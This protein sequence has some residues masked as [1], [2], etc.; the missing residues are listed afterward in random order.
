MP[1]LRD[2]DKYRVTTIIGEVGD[3]R[4][5]NVIIVDNHIYTG[6]NMKT[7]LD[8]VKSKSPRS[9]TTAVLF[10][11]QDVPC[12]IEPDIWVWEEKTEP[13]TVPWAF[14]EVHHRGYGKGVFGRRRT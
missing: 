1:V 5:K 11:H 3:I 14:T 10:K 6:T 8:F 7:A 9:V 13:M 2:E 4:G 12:V